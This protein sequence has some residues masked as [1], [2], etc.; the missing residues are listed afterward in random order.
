MT[1]TPIIRHCDHCGTDLSIRSLADNY[2]AAIG[3]DGLTL[4]GACFCAHAGIEPVTFDYEPHHHEWI[5]DE[6]EGESED[7]E[8]LTEEIEAI[9]QLSL[10]SA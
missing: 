8:E 2:P 5:A 10:W 1:F 6:P 3:C 9:A 7:V 4:C